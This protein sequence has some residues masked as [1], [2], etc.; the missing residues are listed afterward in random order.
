[1]DFFHFLTNTFYLLS[2]FLMSLSFLS[3]FPLSFG[4]IS[5][6][7][8][9]IWVITFLGGKWSAGEDFNGGENFSLDPI[10]I[11]LSL[12][13]GLGSHPYLLPKSSTFFTQIIQLS[14]IYRVMGMVKWCSLLV[15]AFLFTLVILVYW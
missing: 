10:L 2:S 13:G 5:F 8:V 12:V 14:P 1:M 3:L 9:V 15:I 6:M 11:F 4:Y 7:E